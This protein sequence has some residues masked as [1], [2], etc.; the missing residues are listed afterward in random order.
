MLS[1][2]SKLS[3]LN[4]LLMP[5]FLAIIYA[6]AYRFRNKH[7]KKNHP[8]RKYFIPALTL[9][10]I[11]A[12]FIGLIYSLYYKGGDTYYF[13]YHSQI[14]NS[15]LDESFTKWVNLLFHIPPMKDGDYFNY[16]SQMEW[17]EDAASYTIASITA[18]VC[19][20]TLNTYLPAA[21]IFAA[22]SF[23]GSLGFIQ[24]FCKTISAFT[25]VCSNCNIIYSQCIRMGFWYF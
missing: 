3:F 25:Q 11:G 9:K 20:F 19:V 13:Y 17:Y 8:W 1:E 7:Y 4:F 23:T 18:F 15:A 21:I 24:N 16:I 5:F 2:V 22:I 14:I 12:I 10:I 6:V